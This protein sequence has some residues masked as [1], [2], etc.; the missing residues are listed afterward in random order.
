MREWLFKQIFSKLIPFKW[1]D[2]HKTDIARIAAFISGLLLLAQ[3]FFPE[4]LPFLTQ[5]QLILTTILS[6]VG[7]EIGKAHREDK[8]NEKS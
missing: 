6:L 1:I 5:G 2:G 7:V 3:E 4:Y 8:E